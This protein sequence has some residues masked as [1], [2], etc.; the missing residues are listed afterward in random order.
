MVKREFAVLLAIGVARA[1]CPS[2]DFAA[3]LR[4]LGLTVDDPEE[5]FDRLIDGGVAPLNYCDFSRRLRLIAREVPEAPPEEPRPTEAARAHAPSNPRAL[6]EKM[7]SLQA[8]MQEAGSGS[9]ATHGRAD[10]RSHDTH[11]GT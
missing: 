1:Y 8:T 7:Q 11:R 2:E 3:G 5:T 6:Q 9:A 4:Q 10:A